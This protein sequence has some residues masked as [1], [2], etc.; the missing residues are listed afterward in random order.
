MVWQQVVAIA[1]V[2]LGALATV[3][4]VGKPRKIITPGMAA[5]SL[6]VNALFI[7]M[8]ASI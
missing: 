6:V 4:E 1:V 7:W 5:L 3:V 2:A 8:I